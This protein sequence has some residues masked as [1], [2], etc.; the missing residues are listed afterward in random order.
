MRKAVGCEIS[1]FCFVKKRECSI[2]NSAEAAKLSVFF[3]EQGWID[4]KRRAE[5]AH[6]IFDEEEWK[7]EAFCEWNMTWLV[8]EDALGVENYAGF[9]LAEMGGDFRGGPA[10]FDGA[11]L[12]VEEGNGVGGGEEAGLGVEEFRADGVEIGHCTSINGSSPG[13]VN[14]EVLR[15]AK[16]VLRMTNS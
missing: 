10:R 9:D 7:A 5:A 3:G 12:P 4:G 1:G 2:A 13:W 6:A 15:A 8:L 14:V 11:G 16:A